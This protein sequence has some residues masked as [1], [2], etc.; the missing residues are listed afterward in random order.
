MAPKVS[1]EVYPQ[2]LAEKKQ[3]AC[4]SEATGACM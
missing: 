2:A 1:D 3:S 4:C